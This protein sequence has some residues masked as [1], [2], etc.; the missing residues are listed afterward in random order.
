MI[1]GESGFHHRKIFYSYCKT[2]SKT[3]KHVFFKKKKKK[4]RLPEEDFL[5]FCYFYSDLMMGHFVQAGIFA[6][7]NLWHH[8][9]SGTKTNTN[10]MSVF[11]K[12]PCSSK[13]LKPFCSHYFR[14][15]GVFLCSYGFL[16]Y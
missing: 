16:L 5:D 10:F 4:I 13:D 6:L 12:L 11:L 15:F 2:L 7:N 1:Q 8:C 14:S 3:G 9:Y